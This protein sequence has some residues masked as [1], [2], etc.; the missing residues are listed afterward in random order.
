MHSSGV[1]NVVLEIS[2]TKYLYT[3][4]LYDWVRLDLDGNPRPL[5]V[6]RGLA[7]LDFSRQGDVIERELISHPSVVGEGDGWRREHLPTP[8]KHFYDVERVELQPGA[9]TTLNTDRSPQVLTVVE[10][11]P[12]SLRTGMVGGGGTRAP[13]TEAECRFAET[14]LV[15]AAAESFELRNDGEVPAKVV[16]AFMKP[17]TGQA[18]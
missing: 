9:A 14:Y 13:E 3:F 7:N 1:G 8:A 6:E 12:V 2:N 11:G 15:P 17:V 16:V 10:G 18:R 4:K 5:N